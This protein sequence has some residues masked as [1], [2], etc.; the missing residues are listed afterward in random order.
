VYP[1]LEIIVP[2]PGMPFPTATPIPPDLPRGT[3]ID[4]V[5]QSGDSLANIASIFNST[6]EA[7][8]EENDLADPNAIYVGQLLV[9][10]ANLVTPTP[11]LPPT[12]TPAV[13]RT[14]TP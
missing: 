6:V 4:Y 12:S 14:P 9:V 8:I 10:P 7:I 11:T 5:V 3:K 1:G 13:S 2:N